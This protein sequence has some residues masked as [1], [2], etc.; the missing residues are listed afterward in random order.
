M[1]TIFSDFDGVWRI[2]KPN[3]HALKTSVRM[4]LGERVL[5]SS[6]VLVEDVQRKFNQLAKA[7]NVVWL[8]T[9]EES[10]IFFEP[11]IGLTPQ[12]W[13]PTGCVGNDDNCF[14]LGKF[15]TVQEFVVAHPEEPVI[16]VEDSLSEL[17]AEFP[18]HEEWLVQHDVVLVEPISNVG[19]TD[20]QLQEIFS[21]L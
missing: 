20:A 6:I 21:S 10:T 13:V 12:P 16:W 18:E 7:A 19:I 5:S 8:T 3:V 11:D 17:F 9:W 14:L 1:T 2:Q 15:N 4:I